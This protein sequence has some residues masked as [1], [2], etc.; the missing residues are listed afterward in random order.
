MR[1]NKERVGSLGD[2][3]MRKLR[4]YWEEAD[5]TPGEQVS[6]KGLGSVTKGEVYQE[7]VKKSVH[8]STP[9]TKLRGE[10]PQRRTWHPIDGSLGMK[11]ANRIGR[12]MARQRS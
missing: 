5:N 9:S 12:N 2:I 10:L 8:E 6:I 1:P 11:E 4:E 3:S 7:L